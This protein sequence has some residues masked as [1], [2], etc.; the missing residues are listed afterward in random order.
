M[1]PRN[2]SRLCITLITAG[3]ILAGCGTRPIQP[4]DKHIQ[5]PVAQD[6]AADIPQ[7]LT[8]TVALPAPKYVAKAETYSVVVTNV[9]AQEI[10]FALAR[11]AKINLDIHPGIQGSVTLN[12]LNQTLPQILTRIAKQVDMRYELDNGNLIVMPDTPYLHSY[13][14]DYVNMSREADGTISNTSQ[15]GS[16]TTA[17]ASATGNNSSLSIKG[18]SKNHFWDTLTKNIT[19]ILRETDKILPDGSSETV[20]EQT[21]S[22]DRIVTDKKNTAKKTGNETT[23]TQ[24]TIQEGDSKIVTRRNTFR[25]AASVIANPESGIITVRATGKQHEKVQEFIDQ[26]MSSARRQV[27]IEAT[28]VEVRLNDNYKQGIDWSLLQRNGT[29]FQLR[30]AATTGLPS[31]NTANLFTLNYLNP[32][33]RLGNLSASVALLE[34]FGT[35]KVLSSPKLSVM[36]NQTA[37]LRVVDNKVYFIVNSSTTPCSPAPCTPI[38]TYT[39]T[40]NTVPVGF[41][42]SVTPQINDSDTVLLNVRPSITRL[43]APAKDPTPGLIIANEIPQTSTREMESVLKID[44]NQIAV[45]GGLMEDRIDNFTDEI[46]GASRIPIAGELFK[47]RNDTS[48]KT[49]LVIFLRP[50]VIKDASI[51]G[52]FS[53]YRN[54]L[55]DQN[56]FKEP[57]SGKP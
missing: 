26:I 20:T 21:G 43:L 34:S 35:V 57:T 12:A 56:F 5:R 9:P 54:M 32:S 40:V 27:L 1:H 49:E 10:L 15:L 44:N 31:A 33:S 28:V 45:L 8:R 11:D 2:L 50:V 19:D 36:N 47:H 37:M 22:T 17:G 42:M 48:T 53:A 29:G 38:I 13:K 41:T 55:P 4:S 16:G 39:T 6:T 18:V 14:I 24:T 7:A 30:Q 3:A 23:P 25:E 51:E 46:P 52:D